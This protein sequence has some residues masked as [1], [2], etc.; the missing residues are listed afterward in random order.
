MIDPIIEAGQQNLV[1]ETGQKKFSLVPT[2]LQEAMKYAEI[3]S[4]S[5]IVPKDYKGK[6]GNVL[7]AIQYG[8]ELGLPPM[9]ALQNIAVINGRPCL[10]GDALK[11]VCV[12]SPLCEWVTE[13]YDEETET[14]YCVVKRIGQ[15]PHSQSF[16]IEDAKKANLLG[17]AG[18]WTQY[19]R[20]MLQMRAR[21]FAL[22]DVF[23]DLLRGL[24]S[25]EEQIDILEHK[26]ERIK[27]HLE[28]VSKQIKDH[29]R[30]P[31]VEKIINDFNLSDELTQI[32]KGRDYRTLPIDR[33]ERFEKYVLEMDKSIDIDDSKF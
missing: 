30:F 5:D 11:A 21:G 8:A 15:E 31:E 2:S 17:K 23:P 25:A 6:A 10:W 27:Q 19:T 9:Q 16:S 13:N 1:I 29:A 18:P 24:S 22:R 12:A 4:R 33:F 28:L 26:K 20:R 32:T 3:I 14:F 7:V